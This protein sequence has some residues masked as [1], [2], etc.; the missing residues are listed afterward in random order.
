MPS[1]A[2]ARTARPES[3]FATVAD[4]Y[5]VSPRRYLAN[6]PAQD[7]RQH[8]SL[9]PPGSAEHR[10][11]SAALSWAQDNPEDARKAAQTA[12]RYA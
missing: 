1:S 9:P 7:R 3:R 8:S 11:G 5:G 6:V 10:A 2:P 4:F 12:A